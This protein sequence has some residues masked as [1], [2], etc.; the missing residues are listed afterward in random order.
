VSVFHSG[1]SE[2]LK[3][4]VHGALGALALV[5]TVYNVTA[6]ALRK[7]PHLAVNAGLYGLLTL[8]EAKKVQHHRG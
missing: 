5:C 1:E 4:S 3:G 2:T 6:Y 7:E 8:W